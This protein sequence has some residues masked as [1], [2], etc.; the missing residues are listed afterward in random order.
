MDPWI[1][2]VAGT[3]TLLVVA[4]AAINIGYVVGLLPVTG[5]TL[6]LISYG[7]SSLLVTMAIFG[8]LA[9]SARN[10]PQAVAAL[11]RSPRIR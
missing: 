3:L 1:R 5:V 11:R 7:G 9:N 10:E 2:I 6:P 8:L 4:Q